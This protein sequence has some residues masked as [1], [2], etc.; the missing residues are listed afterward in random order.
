M[1]GVLKKKKKRNNMPA[2]MILFKAKQSRVTSDCFLTDKNPSLQM[3]V[4]VPCEYRMA[5]KHVKYHV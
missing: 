2:N 1:L 4:N 5:L 3:K